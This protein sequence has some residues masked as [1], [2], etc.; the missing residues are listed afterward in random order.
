MGCIQLK[1]TEEAIN[2]ATLNEPC[3]EQQ[4]EVGAYEGER[5]PISLLQSPD[6]VAY[7]PI[8]LG[9]LDRACDDRWGV[10]LIVSCVY[11]EFES[12]GD[13]VV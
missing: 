6:T 5:R 8:P 3:Y 1:L 11:I 9:K 13:F 4:H 12:L 10:Y 2:A 7:L